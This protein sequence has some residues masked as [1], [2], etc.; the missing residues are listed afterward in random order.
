MFVFQLPVKLVSVPA[1]KERDGLSS[2][3]AAPTAV[4]E[5]SA[6]A[7]A[8]FRSVG[9]QSGSLNSIVNEASVEV[10]NPVWFGSGPERLSTHH[11]CPN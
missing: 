6:A 2:R 11:A 9:H 7:A 1:V 3:P 8:Q 10:K 5:G 4:I